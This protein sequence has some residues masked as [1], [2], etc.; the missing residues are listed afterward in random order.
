VQQERT[1]PA[2]TPAEAEAPAEE[3]LT[4]TLTEAARRLGISKALAHEA[5]NRGGA[6]R[7]HPGSS[8]GHGMTAATSR[9]SSARSSF[10]APRSVP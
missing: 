10:G 3:R 7:A 2:P 5:A 6:D 4:Y 9:S 1:R 8:S